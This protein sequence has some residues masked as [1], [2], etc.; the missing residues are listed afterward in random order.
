M[1]STKKES[2]E[3]GEKN[4]K[5]PVGTNSANSNSANTNPAKNKSVRLKRFA[6][7]AVIWFIVFIILLAGI[8]VGGVYTPRV[9]SWFIEHNFMEADDLE[10]VDGQVRREVI[11]E[12]NMVIDVVEKVHESVVSIA[13]SEVSLD[14]RRGVV[15]DPVN[16]G[17]GFVID[18]SGL[19]LTNQHVV[20]SQTEKYVVVTSDG[21]EYSVEEISRDNVNDLAILKVDGNGLESLALGDSDNLSVGQFVIAVGTPFG[22]FPGSVTTGVVSGL[23][24]SVTAGG[25]FWGTARTYEDVIQTDAAINPGNSGGPLLD[26]AGSVIGICFATTSGAD[27]IS[28]AIPINRAAEKISEYKKYGKFIKPY[29][30]VEYEIISPMQAMFYSDVVPGALVKGVMEDS[31]AD[32]A[33]IQK[34]DIIVKIEDKPVESSFSALIQQYEVGDS[35]EVEIW[36]NGESMNVTVVLEEA[37]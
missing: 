4:D 31:P 12:E 35:I 37:V 16:I 14:R 6:G 8:V 2:R 29:M 30:G 34:M 26:V 19:I 11:N 21:E 1:G 27:N 28:F 5:K 33:E 10:D 7:C 23:G 22:D 17:T 3:K 18:D 32:K 20:S 15:G 13:V 36:R 25:G 24:R 9:K